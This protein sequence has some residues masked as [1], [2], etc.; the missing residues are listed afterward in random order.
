M[1]HRRH[2][3]RS[4]RTPPSRHPRAPPPGRWPP[5]SGRLR[6]RPSGCPCC[7]G[8]GGR[9]YA[10]SGSSGG[11]RR[12]RWVSGSAAHCRSSG[13]AGRCLRRLVLLAVSDYEFRAAFGFGEPLLFEFLDE[14]AQGRL[15]AGGQELLLDRLFDRREGLLARGRDAQNLVDV[16]AERGLDRAAQLFDFGPEDSRVE[17]LLLRAFDDAVDDPA[18]GLAGRVDRDLFGNGREFLARF[19][20]LL[21]SAG[22][23]FGL[24]EDDLDVAS[25]G[26]SVA[27]LVFVVVLLHVSR[28]DGQ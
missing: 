9:G 23:R 16:I 25:F 27:R 18:G 13:G 2:A 4:P 8:S 20:F 10:R 15:L 21:R 5:R 12:S 11:P 17:F 14:V 26:R 24:R 7:R 28:R 6:P 19:D 1:P 3:A 22:A